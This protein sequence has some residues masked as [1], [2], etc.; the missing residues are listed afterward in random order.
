MTP[1]VSNGKSRFGTNDIFDGT[2]SPEAEAQ[3]LANGGEWHRLF[4]NNGAIALFAGGEAAAGGGGSLPAALYDFTADG[5]L[6]ARDETLPDVGWGRDPR[7]A[8]SLSPRSEGF[9]L[10]G[11]DFGAPPFAY[12]G[13]LIEI[14]GGDEIDPRGLSRG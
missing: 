5:V 12:V 9:G 3:R 11:I 4:G 8:A 6:A 7:P 2:P 10:A 1:T 14:H 13:E